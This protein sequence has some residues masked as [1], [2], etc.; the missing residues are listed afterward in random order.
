MKCISDGDN[1]QIAYS[2]MHAEARKQVVTKRSEV[3]LLWKCSSTR[4]MPGAT[5]PPT[6]L[7]MPLKQYR[8]HLSSSPYT[9]S[10]LQRLIHNTSIKTS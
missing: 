3:C 2:S 4:R 5:H 8:K 6:L 7:E 10:W 9:T 1:R